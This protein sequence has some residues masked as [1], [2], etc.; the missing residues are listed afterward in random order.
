M[1][2]ERLYL[3]RP[4]GLVTNGMNEI[5]EAYEQQRA[6]MQPVESLAAAIY[7]VFT[8]AESEDV[9][10]FLNGDQD[11]VFGAGSGENLRSMLLNSCEQFHQMVNPN[12]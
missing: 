6:S 8:Q 1:A 3:P 10:S 12:G 11:Q 7:R 2:D 5:M 4:V 9:I